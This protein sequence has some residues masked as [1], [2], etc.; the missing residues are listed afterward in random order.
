MVHS[1]VNPELGQ[2]EASVQSPEGTIQRLAN[3]QSRREGARLG[4]AAF[5]TELIGQR[6]GLVSDNKGQVAVF[7][8]MRTGSLAPW[9]AEALWF[10]LDRG[11]GR[12]ESRHGKWCGRESITCH[13]SWT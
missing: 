10:C 1:L 4:L 13:D 3:S 2:K 5:E 7:N 12:R 8:N 11:T 6:V 9:M